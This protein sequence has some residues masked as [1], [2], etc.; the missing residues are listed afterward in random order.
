MP[1]YHAYRCIVCRQGRGDFLTADSADA[2]RR[3]ISDALERITVITEC[4]RTWRLGGTFV[5][6]HGHKTSCGATLI[7][8]LGA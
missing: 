3:D 5:A 7:S 2:G 6:L 8:S 4:D 1:E